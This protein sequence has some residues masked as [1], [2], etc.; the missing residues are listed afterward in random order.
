MGDATSSTAPLTASEMA[1]DLGAKLKASLQSVFQN[2]ATRTA[3]VHNETNS[4]IKADLTEPNH[5][6]PNTALI[7]NE[8]SDRHIL[9]LCRDGLNDADTHS[10]TEDELL[11]IGKPEERSAFEEVDENLLSGNVTQR[12]VCQMVCYCY[13]WSADY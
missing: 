8:N 5:L 12:S 9:P 7:N 10:K 4:H 2:A 1:S 6:K 11:G 3:V 13:V